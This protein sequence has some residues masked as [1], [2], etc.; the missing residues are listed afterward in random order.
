MS[1]KKNDA[2]PTDAD[3]DGDADEV[4][5]QVTVPRRVKRALDVRA[6]QTGQTKRSIVLEGLRLIGLKVSDDEVT[7]RRGARRY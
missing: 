5:L 2:A 6:A 1:A 3:H 4:P 7:G